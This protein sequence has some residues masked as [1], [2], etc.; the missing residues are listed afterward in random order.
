[1]AK[2]DSSKNIQEVNEQMASYSS[3]LDVTLS[4]NASNLSIYDKLTNP[5]DRPYSV[6]E[7]LKLFI[8]SLTKEKLTESTLTYKV[9]F[10]DKLF[11]AKAI[12][13]GI[14]YDLFKEIRDNSPFNDEQWSEFL[15]ISPRTLSRYNNVEN[16]I[17]KSSQSERILEL[18]EVI[19]SGYRVFDAADDFQNWLNSS[20]QALGFEKPIN[21]LNS[22]YG[23]DLIMDELHSIEYGIFT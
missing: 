11:V 12:R 9:L 3:S 20:S 2:K 7:Q 15:D 21:L 10:N 19:S 8:K 22:S 17:F 4:L 23:K 13:K 14:P 18:A 1:M 5:I 16:H 6:T